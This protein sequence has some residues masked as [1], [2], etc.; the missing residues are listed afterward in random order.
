M[1]VFQHMRENVGQ[2]LQESSE[3]MTWWKSPPP[4]PSG[5]APVAILNHEVTLRMEASS[6]D[7]EAKSSSFDS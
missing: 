7:A 2:L 6:Q 5:V 4:L 1:S 3:E